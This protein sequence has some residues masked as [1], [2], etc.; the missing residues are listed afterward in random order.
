[1]KLG[2]IRLDNTCY[3]CT[4]DRKIVT[5]MIKKSEY[6]KLKLKYIC[7][8]QRYDSLI[9]YMNIYKLTKYKMLQV[10]DNI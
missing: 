4:N 10:D 7:K 8:M 5:C 3:K 9:E 6:C 1:M 2:S